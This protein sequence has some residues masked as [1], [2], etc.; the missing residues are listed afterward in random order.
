MKVRRFCYNIGLILSMFIGIWHFFVPTLFQ[1]SS[2]I[3]S[4]YKNLIVGIEWTNY[5]F[6][7]LLTG[8]SI[9]LILWRKKFL[10]GNKET[11]VIYSFM[12]FLW[13]NRIAIA[14]VNPWP[15]EPIAWVSYGQLI[16][17]I[18]VFVMLLIPLVFNI[19][20]KK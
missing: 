17:A 16:G 20:G 18:I 9:I 5:C 7:L 2:Y 19:K 11:L 15:L 10:E 14:I 6:S 12:V 4:E 1:W 8:L 3:S 13:F